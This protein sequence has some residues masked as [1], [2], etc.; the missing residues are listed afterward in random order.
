[1]SERVDDGGVAGAVVLV[2]LPL[3][4]GPML[5]RPLQGDIGVG[6]VEH[7]AHRNRLW[8]RRFQ[9]KLG[10]FVGQ[11][12]NPVAD[13]Q[14]GVPDAAVVHLVH[15]ADQRRAEGVDVPGD[16]L[17][18]IADGQVRQCCRTRRCRRHL[19]LHGRLVQFSDGGVGAAHDNSSCSIRLGFKEIHGRLQTR[20]QSCRERR[21][22]LD[23]KLIAMQHGQ[24][25]V[26]VVFSAPRVR[27]VHD[28]PPSGSG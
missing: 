23:R 8:I 28:N 20:A 7:Q 14:L 27:T 12:E 19:G 26:A 4:D 6:H 10:I 13:L 25:I 22:G 18:R 1:M 17:A 3:H 11:V 5:A 2:G 15:L 24:R 16:G 21:V 9:A